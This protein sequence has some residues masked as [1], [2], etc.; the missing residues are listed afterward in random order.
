MVIQRNRSYDQNHN[1]KW[2]V[3]FHDTGWL[4]ANISLLQTSLIAEM[5][6]V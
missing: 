2:K 5:E 4:C 3:I 1:E 6:R